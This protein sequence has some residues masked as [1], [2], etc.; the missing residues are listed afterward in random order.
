[1]SVKQKGEPSKLRKWLAASMII[2][3]SFLLVTLMIYAFTDFV[4]KDS[5]PVQMKVLIIALMAFLPFNL[6][7]SAVFMLKY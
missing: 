6:L 1:M 4:P 3:S 7:I 2:V 5:Q